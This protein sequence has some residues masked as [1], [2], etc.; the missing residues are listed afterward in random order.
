MIDEICVE[1]RFKC[2]GKF[3]L[4]NNFGWDEENKTIIFLFHNFVSINSKQM[5]LKGTFSKY[6]FIINVKIAVRIA[7]RFKNSNLFVGRP[8]Y[9]GIIV[10]VIA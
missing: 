3:I 6:L 4:S 9:V 10:A 5:K 1:T 7:Y 8:V 2:H